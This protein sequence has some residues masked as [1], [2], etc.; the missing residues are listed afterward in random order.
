[1]T[2]RGRRGVVSGLLLA[3]ALGLVAGCQTWLGGMTLPSG[4]YLSD[5]PDY[6]P[7]G[8]SFPLQRELAAQKA[9]AANLG[10]VN[11]QPAGP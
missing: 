8:P 2:T 6:I 7:P 4:A 1:M 11:A 9:A 5:N 10:G 3:M